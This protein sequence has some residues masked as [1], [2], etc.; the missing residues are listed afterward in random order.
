MGETN[1]TRQNGENRFL[2][3]AGNPYP[4]RSLAVDEYQAEAVS[5]TGR[6]IIELALDGKARSEYQLK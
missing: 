4:S 1:W 2:T 6:N 5:C 3:V